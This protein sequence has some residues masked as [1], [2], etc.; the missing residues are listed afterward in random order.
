LKDTPS[1]VARAY[2]RL[3]QRIR[4]R[5][6]KLLRRTFD[7]TAGYDEVIALRDIPFESF[8]EH[9]LAPITGFATL[10]TRH[11]PLLALV[12]A[13]ADEIGRDVDLLDVDRAAGDTPAPGIAQGVAR[14]GPHDGEQ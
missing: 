4:R 11:S 8:C 13:A 3:V 2:K 6:G 14:L 1:R 7:E 10:D 12:E 9:H 5:P